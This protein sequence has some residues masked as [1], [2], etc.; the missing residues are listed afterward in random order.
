MFE[1]WNKTSMTESIIRLWEANMK[2]QTQALLRLQ[3]LSCRTSND[4]HYFCSQANRAAYALP[5][6]PSPLLAFPEV[7]RGVYS[8]S[9]FS[10]VGHSSLT[11]THIIKATGM[12]I[13]NGLIASEQGR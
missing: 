4:G 9:L 8:N 12:K 10:L 2:M 6:G 7:G 1:V 13:V 11:R 3:A 5:Q